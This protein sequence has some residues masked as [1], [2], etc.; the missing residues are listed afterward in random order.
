MFYSKIKS[1]GSYVPQNIVPKE[2]MVKGVDTNDEC[3]S[4]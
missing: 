1:V 3:M 4:L 2:D